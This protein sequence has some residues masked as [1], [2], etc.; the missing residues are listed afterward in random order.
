MFYNF[1]VKVTAGKTEAEPEEQELELTHGVIHLVE[2]R[3]RRGTDFRVGC[4]LFRFEH[5][6][7]PTNPDEDLRDDGRAIT[8]N[9]HYELLEAP[10]TLKVKAYAPTAGYDHTIY[11]RIGVLPPEVLNPFAVFGDLL[12]KFFRLIGMGK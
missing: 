9:E 3:F 2:V 5:Q 1:A 6:I 8:F 12:Q 7:F 4:R 11:I 10:Y